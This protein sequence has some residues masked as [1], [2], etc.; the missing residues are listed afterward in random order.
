M[1]RNF[2]IFNIVFVSLLIFGC[3]STESDSSINEE[4]TGSKLLIATDQKLNVTINIPDFPFSI[5]DAVEIDPELIKAFA[6]EYIQELG[7]YKSDAEFFL[8]WLP[9][10][11]ADRL[12]SENNDAA[13][14]KK[15]LGNLYISGYFGGIWL[16]DANDENSAQAKA[17]AVE[18]LPDDVAGELNENDPGLVFKILTKAIELK[19]KRASGTDFEAIASARLSITPF[20]MIYGYNWGYFDYILN[21]PPT[22]AAGI[23]PDCECSRMLDCSVP[24]IKLDTLDKYKPYR[25]NLEEP[26]NSSGIEAMR[27]YEMK[28]LMQLWA[29][30]AVKTGADVW[31]NIM[32]D[33]MSI[34][35]YELLLDLSAR[36]MLV[37]EMNLMPAMKGFTESNADD[38][39]C[40]LFQQAAMIAWAGSY[41]MGLSSD[42]APGT[43]PEVKV[44]SGQR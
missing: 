11:S 12:C 25:N 39:R 13:M 3:S 1:S 43:F 5:N 30:G 14:K 23:V 34:Q 40:G 6:L 9:L 41:F 8:G 35:S 38:C 32:N 26:G 27:L 21:N 33:N 18:N 24:A 31:E 44:V 4:S 17:L 22:G 10:K 19:V 28:F 36:F 7:G 20:L 16:R 2:M 42:A 37:A 15:L 29:E